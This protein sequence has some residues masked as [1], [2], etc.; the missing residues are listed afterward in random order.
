MA[1]RVSKSKK[2][3]ARSD[4]LCNPTP[5]RALRGVH[6]LRPKVFETRAAEIA[7][8]LN[9]DRALRGAWGLK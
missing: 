3:D 8:R 7:W 2:Q 9:H 4:K 6:V 1:K 5:P